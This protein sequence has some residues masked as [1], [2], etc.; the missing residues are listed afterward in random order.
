MLHFM[1]RRRLMRSIVFFTVLVFAVFV[2]VIVQDYL[3]QKEFGIG[4]RIEDDVRIFSNTTVEAS[5]SDCKTWVP[6][7]SDYER[8]DI[9]RSCAIESALTRSARYPLCVLVDRFEK[10]DLSSFPWYHR[11]KTRFPSRLF[12]FSPSYV[13]VFAG[14][15]FEDAY[16]NS[17]NFGY[18]KPAV[19]WAL[20]WKYGGLVISPRIIL[21]QSMEAYF[22]F[23]WFDP[24][25]SDI[26]TSFM[27][28]QE[29][30]HDLPKSVLEHLLDRVQQGDVL[31]EP[32]VLSD[33]EWSMKV[34]Q[35]CGTPVSEVRNP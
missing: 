23:L 34:E 29:K 5:L 9:V 27:Q 35:F 8:F 3:T 22:D 30:E 12:T 32:I 25:K 4:G 26:S 11:L 20:L 17:D 31:E 6:V 1:F 28:F 15:M 19:L 10:V 2:V 24:A 21:V 7:T 16:V 18:L 13:S 14:T 33:T